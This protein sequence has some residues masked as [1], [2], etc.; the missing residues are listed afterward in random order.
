M[1]TPKISVI[2]PV[3]NVEQY[4]PRCIDS[5]LVQTFTDFE[6]L[7]I[8]DGSTDS[9]GDICDEY[10]KKDNRIRVFHKKNGGVSSAR[11]VGLDN[12]KGEWLAFIDSDDTVDTEYLSLNESE[13]ADIIEKGFTVCDEF[14]NVI[15]HSHVTDKCIS[16]QEE[17]F[18][19]YVNNWIGPLWNKLIRRSIVK[20]SHFNTDVQIGED[21][22][23]FLSFIA[24]I[25]K[26]KYSQIGTYCYFLRNS[27][28]MGRL[29][30]NPQHRI[31]VTFD[32]IKHIENILSAENLY[33]LRN[34]IIYK[35]FVLSLFR[36][37]KFVTQKDKEKVSDMYKNMSSDNLM[38][39]STFGKIK[40]YTSKIIFGSDILLALYWKYSTI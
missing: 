29:E 12:A 19:I 7:L 26:Y 36:F 3:Y 25:R 33:Y 27:S 34:G 13:D 22:L 35:S 10:A 28:A 20:N 32:N 24:N 40:L 17:F 31:R 5:I 11:N 16:S 21:L 6:L 15:R 23:F 2:V 8:D 18:R 30:K 1:D 14:G 9:S 39:V 37:S 4:L 38:Y